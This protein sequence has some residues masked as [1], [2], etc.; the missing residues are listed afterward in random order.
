[1]DNSILPTA[2]FVR[3]QSEKKTYAKTLLDPVLKKSTEVYWVCCNEYVRNRQK[4][5][6]QTP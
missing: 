3:I 2:T 1:M 5:A 4:E 6:W